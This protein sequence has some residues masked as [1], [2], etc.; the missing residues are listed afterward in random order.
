M[1]LDSKAYEWAANLQL[2]ADQMID[3]GE[4]NQY[5][6]NQA[7]LLNRIAA[8]LLVDSPNFKMH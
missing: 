6:V 1:K 4:T 7:T 3:N 5:I 8:E 2:I